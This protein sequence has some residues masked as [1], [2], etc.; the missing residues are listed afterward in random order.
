MRIACLAVLLLL[1]WLIPTRCTAGVLVSPVVVEAHA[2]QLGDE[3]VISCTEMSGS[4]QTVSLSLGL[5]DQ[6]DDGRVVFIEDPAAQ[7]RASQIIELP[8]TMVELAPYE[9]KQIR[10]KV[11]AVDFKS[12]YVVV[13]VRPQ[14]S[15]ISSRLAVLLLLSTASARDD[16][17]L[18][19]MNFNDNSLSLTFHNFGSRHGRAAGVV[20]IYDADGLMRGQFTV[21]S[22][23][24]LPHRQRSTDLSLSFQPYTADF[25]PLE[26]WGR[27]FTTAE[28]H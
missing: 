12:S 22:G 15:R 3:I 6:D 11:N 26:E 4:S 17:E 1:V 27:Q 8:E 9:R 23:R 24:I 16:V 18:A 5:F 19:Q 2:V 14:H 20:A 21:D 28:L 10:L 25:I 13:F 7:A